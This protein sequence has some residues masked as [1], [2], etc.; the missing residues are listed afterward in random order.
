MDRLEWMPDGNKSNVYSTM[1]IYNLLRVRQQ[2]VPWCK[3]ILF[4]KGIPRHKFLSWLFVLD[5]CP[6]K[7]RMVDWGI[8]TDPTCFLCN[9]DLESRDHLLYVFSYSW[10]LW[11]SI[12]GGAGFSTPRDWNVLLGDLE[13]LKSPQHIR[14]LM[15]LAWQAT[16]YCIWERKTDSDTHQ[17]SSRKLIKPSS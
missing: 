8:D 13:R 17:L 12:A 14:L 16:I 2:R 1:A 7:N 3:E 9:S 15:L 6:T 4:S 10:E 11:H 5:R